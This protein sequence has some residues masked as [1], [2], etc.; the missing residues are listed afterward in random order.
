V[1][2]YLDTNFIVALIT[3]EALSGR[4]A[5]FVAAEPGP[6]IV[7]DFATAEFSSVIARQVR[8]EERLRDEASI[9]LERFDVWVGQATSRAELSSVD[10]ALANTYLR[11]L[12]LT[13]L[14]PDALHIAIAHR[15]GASLVTFDRRM[16]AAA[17]TLGVT[18]AGL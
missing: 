8:T 9:V 13:L 17:R 4:A 7:S 5:A 14:T 1:N 6:L 11:R 16:I 15:L 12:D 2:C 3:P 10:I 18:V